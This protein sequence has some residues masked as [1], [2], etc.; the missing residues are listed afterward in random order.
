MPAQKILTSEE[1]SRLLTLEE[2]H[3]VDLKRVE[4]AP[5]KLSESISAFANTAGGE[6]F[7]GI[8]EEA[9]KTTRFWNGFASMEG[10]N[11]LFQVIDRLTPLA[12]HYDATFLHAP[13]QPGH[14]L[15]LVVQKT[16]DIVARLMDT[17][18][19]VEMRRTCASLAKTRCGAY[20]WTKESRVPSSALV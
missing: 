16:R 6:L 20:S 14:V 12:N 8:A 13:G 10:A 4:I 1:V 15:H 3:F 17:P 9:D 11:G 7:V 18:M 5:G 2:G 19:F